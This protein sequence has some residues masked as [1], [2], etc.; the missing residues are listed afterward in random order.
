[1]PMPFLG[2][3]VL[4]WCNKCNIPILEN[5]KCGICKTS[6]VR[7]PITA[8]FDVRPAFD[9][10]LN[11]IRKTIDN[12][13]GKGL[14]Q[15][16]IEDNK[17][18]LLNKAPYFDRMD[19]IVLD[20]AIIGTIRYNISRDISTW[21]F[22]PRIEGAKRIVKYNC[23]KWIRIAKD[24]EPFIRKGANV[25]APGVIEYDPSIE[26]GEYV[27]V[28]NPDSEAVGIGISR[29]SGD[30][31]SNRKKGM[32]IKSKRGILNSTLNILPPGQSWDMVIEANREILEKK[33]NNALNLIKQVQ[34][35]YSLPYVVS[36]SGGKDS[37][38]ILLLVLR[39]GINFK[40]FYL[41]TGIEF[42]E[43]VSYVH[44]IIKDF[45]LKNSFILGKTDTDFFNRIET[46]GVPSKDER[47]CNKLLKLNV[48]KQ[49]IKSN[50]PEGM[51]TFIGNRKYESYSRYQ[52][53]SRGQI[54]KNKLIPQQINA[55]LIMN[56][57]ALHVWLYIFMNKVKYNP[58]YEKGYERIGCMFCPANKLA[59]LEI[60]KG[61]H[62]ESYKKW[63]QILF[64]QAKKLHY[65][66]E[67]VTKGFWRYRN[68]DKWK[69]DVK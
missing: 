5:N 48:I 29:I 25:L 67:W 57:T 66:S 2:K 68:K 8:P 17:I 65:P 28:T 53:S 9:R 55:N 62:P 13:F 4:S 1:M 40:I 19:E 23:Y 54:V 43:T 20:G 41:D 7:V 59:D 63:E 37:I 58:L 11:L 15:K 12:Q 52:E 44:D 31:I 35:K 27:I 22:I 39:S 24:A 21:E 32:I 16:I 34:K 49:I 26:K 42:E 61:I 64:E 3:N 6:T 10:D 46:L 33:E 14:G 51:V 47:W 30:E 18:I 38:C 69:L 45:N 56:W 60:L 50:F 36:F